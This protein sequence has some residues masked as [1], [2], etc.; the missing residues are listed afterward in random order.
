MREV[1]KGDFIS[2][3]SILNILDGDGYLTVTGIQ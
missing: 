1:I 3:N 2:V